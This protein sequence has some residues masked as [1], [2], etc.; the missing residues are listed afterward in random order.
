MPECSAEKVPFNCN[1]WEKGREGFKGK[2]PRADNS[3]IDYLALDDLGVSGG[4]V[5]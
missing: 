4:G 3:N 1:L 5:V 2:E